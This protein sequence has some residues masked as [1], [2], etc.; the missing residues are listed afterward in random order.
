[1]HLQR[2][3]IQTSSSEPSEEKYDYKIIAPSFHKRLQF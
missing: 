2:E 3:T 1:M